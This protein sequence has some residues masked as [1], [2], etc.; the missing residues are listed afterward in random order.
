MSEY[1]SND[2]KM[3]YNCIS[4]GQEENSFEYTVREKF[5]KKC[6]DDE[7]PEG[8]YE[9]FYTCVICK[10]TWIRFYSND[11]MVSIR[12]DLKCGGCEVFC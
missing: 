7:Y 4:C 3:A 12:T 1:K 10:K 11:R 8:Y 9:V 2:A 5:C 6:L